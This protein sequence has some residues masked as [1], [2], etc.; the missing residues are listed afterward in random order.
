V[1][2]FSQGLQILLVAAAIGLFYVAFGLVA[3]REATMVAWVGDGLDRIGAATLF[4]HEVLLTWDLVRVAVLIAALSAVQL[5]F[6]ALT[7]ETYRAEFFEEMLVEIREALATRAVYVAA[8]VE[9][10]EAPDP[11]SG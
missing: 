2:V 1:L 8:L 5:T 10:P 4:G 9:R 11:P 3:I 7:D 6:S